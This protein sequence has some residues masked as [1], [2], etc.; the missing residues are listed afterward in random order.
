M[1]LCFDEFPNCCT[2]TIVSDFD[3]CIEYKQTKSRRYGWETYDY[4]IMHKPTQENIQKAIIKEARHDPSAALMVAITTQ[5]QRDAEIVLR[6]LGF[7]SSKRYNKR[8]HED[9]TIKLWWGHIPK[10][11][12]K[13]GLFDDETDD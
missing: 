11:L 13:Y 6:R 12:G 4:K 5:D 3:E 2:A 10:I 1:N 7:E 9:T 8:R